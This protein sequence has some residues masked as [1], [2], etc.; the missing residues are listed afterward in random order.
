M[1]ELHPILAEILYIISELEKMQDK[2]NIATLKQT[3]QLDNEIFH[4]ILSDLEIKGYVENL[5][6]VL[7]LSKN[8]KELLKKTQRK[9]DKA[10]KQVCAN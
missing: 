6:G 10:G 8:R 4:S 5:G 2:N 7:K 9:S 1:L 3:T